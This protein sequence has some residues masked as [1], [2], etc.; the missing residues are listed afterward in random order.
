MEQQLWLAG[1]RSECAS[2]PSAL[3]RADYQ[4]DDKEDDEQPDNENQRAKIAWLRDLHGAHPCSIDP[5][6]DHREDRRWPSRKRHG[7]RARSIKKASLEGTAGSVQ[8]RHQRRPGL[9]RD[10]CLDPAA[11]P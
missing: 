4:R 5:R 8:D 7:V 9:W 1:R 10:G 3:W 6:A 2:G 11:F